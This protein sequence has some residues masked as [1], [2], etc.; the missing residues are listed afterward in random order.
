MK[1]IA[2]IYAIGS[3]DIKPPSLPQKFSA[4]AR[5]FVTACL[6][7]EQELRPTA[8]DLANHEFLKPLQDT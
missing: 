8:F 7:R 1:P 4:E 3:G 5:N 6:E 2:A